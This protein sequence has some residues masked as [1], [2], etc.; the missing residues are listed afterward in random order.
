MIEAEMETNA[1][2]Q[3]LVPGGRESQTSVIHI[4]RLVTFTCGAKTKRRIL[5]RFHFERQLATTR[6]GRDRAAEGVEETR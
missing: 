6:A 5:E 3:N 2:A 1:I 4:R